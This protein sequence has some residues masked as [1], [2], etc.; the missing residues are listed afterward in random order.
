MAMVEA[1]QQHQQHML[2]MMTTMSRQLETIT[3]RAARRGP[4]RARDDGSTATPHTAQRQNPSE[5]RREL[6]DA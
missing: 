3:S 6:M 5:E 1:Q 2:A 4:R